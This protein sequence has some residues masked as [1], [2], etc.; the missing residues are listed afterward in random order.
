[1]KKLPLSPTNTL[2]NVCTKDLFFAVL[3]MQHITGISRQELQMSKLEDKIGTENTIQFGG[4]FNKY[5]KKLR[6][7]LL[8]NNCLLSASTY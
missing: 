4:F 2:K 7:R 6:M 1:V 5:P 3:T 8:T